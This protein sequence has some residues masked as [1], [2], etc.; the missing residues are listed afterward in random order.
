D[1]AGVLALRVAGAADEFAESS[2]LF[3]QAIPALWTF[4]V[5]RFVRLVRDSCASHQTPCCLAI[6]IARAGQKRAKPPAFDGHFLA[7]ILAIF[8]LAF[9]VCVVRLFS[10]QILDK[11]ALGITRATQEEAVAA[12]ALQQFTLAALF[13]FLAGGNAGLVRHH[14]V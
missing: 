5:E 9:A 14:L 7:T 8:G 12:D 4:F 2:V 13:A 1:R 11:V 3:Q 10:R 6:R